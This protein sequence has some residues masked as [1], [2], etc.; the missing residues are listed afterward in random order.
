VARVTIGVAVAGLPAVIS[1]VLA[2]RR[3]AWPERPWP[4][5]W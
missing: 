5:H 4:H 3:L 1:L 2:A